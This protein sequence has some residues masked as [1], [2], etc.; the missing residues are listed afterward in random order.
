MVLSHSRA[1]SNRQ[2]ADHVSIRASND[3]VKGVLASDEEGLCLGVRGKAVASTSGTALSI[4]TR[5]ARIEK[6]LVS[7]GPLNGLSIDTQEFGDVIVLIE[8]ESSNVLIRQEDGI[9]LAIT[10][11]N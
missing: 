10:S 11:S 7:L 8:G 9:T 5:A 3:R 6:A 1:P 4:A 2:V